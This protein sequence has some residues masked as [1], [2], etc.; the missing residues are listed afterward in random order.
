MKPTRDSTVSG[1]SLRAAHHQVGWYLATEFLTEI[2]ELEQYL[3]PH[4]Q[5]HM[6]IG[7]K[8]LG[9]DETLIVA[10]MRGGEPMAM[11]I[12]EA[13]PRAMFLHAKQP[14]DMTKGHVEGKKAVFLV[15]SV[16]NS[17]KSVKEFVDHV[18]ALD[19]RIRIAVVA[20]VVQERAITDVMR[21]LSRIADL[22]LVAL[23]LSEKKFTGQGGTDTGNRLFN[24][25]NL[26]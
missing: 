19:S 22:S 14:E 21:P 10:L 17:G 11:G 3:I 5:G 1:P 7:H 26:A 18:R 16:I 4:V 20:G 25:T 15:D 9:E 23:R 2:L 13:M 6:V 24:T 8:F 12:S